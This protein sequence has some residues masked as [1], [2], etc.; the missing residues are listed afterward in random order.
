MGAA[1]SPA[2]PWEMTRRPR[3]N[4]GGTLTSVG[5]LAIVATGDNR[6]TER[7]WAALSPKRCDQQTF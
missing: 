7:T 2:S 4:A 1:L 5:T 3:E 6:Q